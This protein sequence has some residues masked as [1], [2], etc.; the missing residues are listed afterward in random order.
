MKFDASAVRQ[1]VFQFLIG[2]LQTRIVN[3]HILIFYPFQF[4]IGNLQTSGPDGPRD[5][6]ILF[7]FL[8]G[9]LQTSESE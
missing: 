1:L 9:N 2:N 5:V 4:L 8:I 3:A 7:Q 6:G